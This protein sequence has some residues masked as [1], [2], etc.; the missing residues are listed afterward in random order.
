MSTRREAGRERGEIRSR[1]G[2]SKRESGRGKQL[3]L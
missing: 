3:I 1:E 2:K